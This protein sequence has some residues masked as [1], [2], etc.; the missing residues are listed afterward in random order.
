MQEVHV[1]GERQLLQMDEQARQVDPF[2]YV[3]LGQSVKHLP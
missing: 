3:P 2:P 1:V